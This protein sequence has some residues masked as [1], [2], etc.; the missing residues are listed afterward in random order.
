MKEEFNSEENKNVNDPS[1]SL[2]KREK[3]PLDP[4]ASR[5]EM[6]K[7]ESGEWIYPGKKEDDSN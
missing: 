7:D 5:I 3:K 2:D 6:V 4:H 1:K